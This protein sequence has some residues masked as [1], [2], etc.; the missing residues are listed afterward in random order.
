VRTSKLT[1]ICIVTSIFVLAIAVGIFVAEGV[2]HTGRRPLLAADQRQAV[3]MANLNA[4]DLTDISIA[5]IDGVAL[6]AWN[7]RPRK[8]FGNTVILSHGLS[9]NRAGMMAYAQFFLRH[10]YDVLM[11]DARAHGVSAAK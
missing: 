6:R 10:G 9:D 5:A 2:L 11:P 8:S 7:F 1:F 4:S 3:E